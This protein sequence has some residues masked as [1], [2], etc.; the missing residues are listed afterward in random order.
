MVAKNFSTAFLIM[1]VCLAAQAQPFAQSPIADNPITT[2]F[3]RGVVVDPQGAR[4]ITASVAV[5]NRNFRLQ[6]KVDSEGLFQI[7][8]PAGRYEVIVIAAGF[9]R[10]RRKLTV[11][12]GKTSSVK[13]MLKPVKAPDYSKCAKSAP[14]L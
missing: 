9:E 8:L 4:V 3:L 2:T 14:C 5:Q 7:P 13:I 11:H 12:L 1:L 6:S 10:Y